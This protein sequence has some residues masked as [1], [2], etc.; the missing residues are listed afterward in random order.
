MPSNFTG[1]TLWQSLAEPFSTRLIQSVASVYPDGLH[2]PAVQPGT[3]VEI[4]EI[5]QIQTLARLRNGQIVYWSN[6]EPPEG[7]WDSLL[8]SGNPQ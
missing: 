7:G 4:V 8:S 2:D 1:L 3:L 5:Y 6:L